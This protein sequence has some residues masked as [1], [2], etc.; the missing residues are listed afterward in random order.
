ML[1]PGPIFLSGGGG[2]GGRGESWGYCSAAD[3]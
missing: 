2:G 3:I 1:I